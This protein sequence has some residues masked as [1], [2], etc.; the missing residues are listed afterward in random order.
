MLRRSLYVL[1]AILLSATLCHALEL[2]QP[3][4]CDYGPGC[5]VQNYV[6]VDSSP[7]WHDF[8]C[9]QLTYDG[10]KGTDFRVSWA[11]YQAGVEVLAAAPGTVLGVRDGVED[12]DARGREDEV[13]SIGLGNAVIVEHDEGYVTTYAHMKQGSIQVREGDVVLRGQV[14]GLV[15][16]SGLTTFPHLHFGVNHDEV[17]V[18]PFAGEVGSLSGKCGGVPA[19]LWTLDAQ[20]KMHYIA[21][22]L[23]QAGFAGYKPEL[24]ALLRTPQASTVSA[25]S[26][27]LVYAATVYGVRQGDEVQMR[28]LD[29]SGAVFA[30]STVPVEKNQAQRLVYI[31]RKLGDRPHWPAGVYRGEFRLIR[32]GKVEVEALR[33]VEVR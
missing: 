33:A 11:S 28:I 5:F 4:R 32:G 8:T 24:P 31:G 12:R 30:R 13:R 1:L 20:I 22:G 17:V 3:I 15:G 16:L 21:T 27:V 25:T 6:D 29:P 23:L 7:D 14:L 2:S 9:G 10:H 18:C 26:P 19:P